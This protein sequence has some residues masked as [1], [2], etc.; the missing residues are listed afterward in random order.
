MNLIENS[1]FFCL[2]CV[3]V[4]CPNC[5]YEEHKN[6][7][8][9]PSEEAPIA[10]KNVLRSTLNVIQKRFLQSSTEIKDCV[11]KIKKSS[12]TIK[13]KK[14]SQRKRYFKNRRN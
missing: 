11:D 8:Y 14:R 12:E 1:I 5:S 13:E 2:T 3:K 4:V 6:H 9:V 7:S 10:A